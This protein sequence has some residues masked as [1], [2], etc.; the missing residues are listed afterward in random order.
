MYIMHIYIYKTP[1]TILYSCAFLLGGTVVATAVRGTRSCLR[2]RQARQKVAARALLEVHHDL[3]LCNIVQSR[4][5]SLIC[6]S[7]NQLHD[8]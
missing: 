8:V 3:Y 4:F 6:E 1:S 2:C 5:S 7:L